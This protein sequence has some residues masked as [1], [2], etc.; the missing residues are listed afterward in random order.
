MIEEH[1]LSRAQLG[2]QPDERA[3]ILAQVNKVHP[4]AK[5]LSADLNL[6]NAAWTVELRQ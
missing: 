3:W 5:I 6:E 2:M 1:L 4:G